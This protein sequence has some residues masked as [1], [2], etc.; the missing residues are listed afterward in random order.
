MEEEVK[1]GLF[2]AIKKVNG[3]NLSCTVFYSIG[4]YAGIRNYLNNNMISN[5]ILLF[6]KISK[7]IKQNVVIIGK[8]MQTLDPL[9]LYSRNSQYAY[10]SANAAVFLKF[11]YTVTNKLC[12]E[13]V[14]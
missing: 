2:T 10:K 6:G 5:F 3:C 13:T 11:P 12:R 8:R 7:Q 9:N 1:I 4:F 14:V